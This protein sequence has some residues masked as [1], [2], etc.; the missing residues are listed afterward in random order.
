MKLGIL[1]CAL[2]SVLSL[3]FFS[4]TVTGA[5]KQTLT[6]VYSKTAPAGLD[7]P[8]WGKIKALEVPFDGKEVFAGKKTAVNTKAAFT[9]NE[10]YFWFN[11]KDATQSVTK[12]AWKFDG[13]AWSHLKGDEDR[14]S[15]LF[16]INRITNFATKGCAVTCHVPA[17]APNAKEGKFGTATDA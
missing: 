3:V 13:Q 8:L 2:L 17:G 9:D 4:N 16:E 11:W 12:E 15:L 6:A 1:T 14:I 7:D 5:A 10:V